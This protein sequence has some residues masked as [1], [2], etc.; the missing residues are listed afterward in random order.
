M[1]KPH[2]SRL[3][4]FTWL[5]WRLVRQR[6]AALTGRNWIEIGV[7]LAILTGVF[8]GGYALISRALRFILAQG[9]VGTLLLDRIFYLGW[10]VIFYLLI[11][12]NLITAFSTL[13]RS[14]EVPFLFTTHLSYTEIFRIKF[15]DNL[16]TSS[17]AVL[18]LGLPLALAYGNIKD[19]GGMSLFLLLLVGLIPLLVT[20]AA[21]ALGLLIVLV[22]ATRTIRLRT[23]FILLGLLLAGALWA[24]REFIQSDM[25]V[26][27]NLGSIRYLARYLGNLSQTPFPL[28]PSYWFLQLFAAFQAGGYGELV[29]FAALL[30][31]TAL[32]LW[33]SAR[34]LAGHYYYS[35]WQ[36]M[37][38][39]RIPAARTRPSGQ[40]KP[41]LF[42]RAHTPGRALLFKDLLQFTRTPQQWIQFLLFLGLI[43][44]YLANIARMEYRILTAQDFWNRLVFILNFGFSGFILAS[45]I[46][47]FVFPLVSLEGRNRWLLLVSPVGTSRILTQKLL[48]SVCLFFVLA[49]IVAL[50]SNLLLDQRG[51]VILLS[52]LFLLIMSVTLTCISLGLGAVFP[53]FEETNPMRIVSGV[54]GIIAIS[55]SLVYLGIMVTGLVWITDHFQYGYPPAFQ[56]GVIT[57]LVLVNTGLIYFPLRWGYRAM[58][59]FGV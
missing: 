1:K 42:S 27:G 41:T 37:S 45:L 12:S 56:T 5:R 58:T 3:T 26:A 24:Y 28:I 13:Y 25:V 33:E 53:R 15:T 10:T 44:I 4:M 35:S 30:L 59:R 50:V 43:M 23:S 9:E 52:S 54:G 8:W 40:G 55:V 22:R 14:P 6:I 31:T 34:W 11:I 18:I 38:H 48:A 21:V 49:E 51:P 7:S 47:R 39:R 19:L 2:S 36:I 32:V 46:T 20:A 17:W 57:G 16:I 29:F